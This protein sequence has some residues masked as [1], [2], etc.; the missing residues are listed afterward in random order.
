MIDP[1]RRGQFIAYVR[2]RWQML[3]RSATLISMM[4]FGVFAPRPAWLEGGAARQLTMLA[5]FTMFSL[6]AI[7]MARSR[8]FRDRISPR[9][10]LGIAGG[11]LG[12]LSRGLVPVRRLSGEPRPIRDP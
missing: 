2:H 8:A 10:W 5:A 12:G 7:L 6:S 9:T 4:V 11:F 3:T 1:D